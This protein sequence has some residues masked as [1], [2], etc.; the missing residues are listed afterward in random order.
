MV[1][2]VRG[3]LQLLHIWGIGI[4][5]DMANKKIEAHENEVQQL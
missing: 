1:L 5:I 3:L 2:V 4:R